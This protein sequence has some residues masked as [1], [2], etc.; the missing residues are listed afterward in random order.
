MLRI[1]KFDPNNHIH[2]GVGR[3]GREVG[4][5]GTIDGEDPHHKAGHDAVAAD[6]K[7]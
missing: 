6:W 3:D 5:V 4:G 7:D 2:C 1:N